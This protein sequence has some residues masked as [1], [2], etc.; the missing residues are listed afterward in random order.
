M[1][2]EENNH[3]RKKFSTGLI[4]TI[5]CALLIVA[6]AAWF[7]LSRYNGKTMPETASEIKS[8]MGSMYSE[9]DSELNSVTSDITSEFRSEYDS[10]TSSYNDSASNQN[11][12]LDNSSI[13]SK[14]ES[15][16]ESA[17]EPTGDKV[18]SIPYSEKV[19]A[20]PAEG[21]I[22][23][24]FS[25]TELQYSKTYGDMRLHSGIDIACKKGTF[26]S[27]CGDGKISTIEENS[28][29]GTVVTIELSDGITVKYCS[30][31]N[32]KFKSGDNVKVG[33]IIGATTTIPAECND[34]EHL[35]FE[36][37]EDGIAVSPLEALGL[38]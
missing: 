36:V 25:A 38:E 5:G 8:E 12:I 11:G 17:A 15:M 21:E 31:E 28:Q 4:V 10:L 6:G 19:F 35:H 18:S 29:F 16:T 27:A 13:E 14:P 3:N 30:L 1:D 32:V 26:V 23:K 34:Q 37:Y 7:A 20:M 24:K 2:Y 33:D 9:I 22:I